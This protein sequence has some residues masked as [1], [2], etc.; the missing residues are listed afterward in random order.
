MLLGISNLRSTTSGGDPLV[1]SS[2]AL[3]KIPFLS[4]PLP[5]CTIPPILLTCLLETLIDQIA[6][7]LCRHARTPDGLAHAVFLD[8][9]KRRTS[10]R[11]TTLMVN[12]IMRLVNAFFAQ[13]EGPIFQVCAI[14]CAACRALVLLRT[15][16][17]ATLL[18][19]ITVLMTL[20][21]ISQLRQRA[22]RKVESISNLSIASPVL[23]PI[24]LLPLLFFAFVVVVVVVA[25]S[26]SS[27]PFADRRL[28]I[29]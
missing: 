6:T 26:S 5:L 13:L 4:T 18:C 21:S 8:N 2:M 19:T 23:F 29:H 3:L 22:V 20:A 14:G 15:C 7:N 17:T 1:R 9:T 10:A 16:E 28:R 12:G 27:R 25:V 11:N 24:L